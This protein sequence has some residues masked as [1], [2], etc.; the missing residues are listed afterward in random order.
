MKRLLA[1]GLAIPILGATLVYR[2]SMDKVIK[3]SIILSPDFSQ[4]AFVVKENN[5]LFSVVLNGREVGKYEGILRGSLFFL[6]KNLFFVA[7]QDNRWRAYWGDRKT[8]PYEVVYPD[9]LTFKGENF[10]LVG[11]RGNRFFVNISGTEFGPF[12][13]VLRNSI[14]LGRGYAFA[15]KRGD[16]WEFIFHGK[17][18]GTYP[19]ILVDTILISP[20]WKHWTFIVEGKPQ[21]LYLDGKPVAKY[22][23]FLSEHVKVE[24]GGKFFRTTYGPRMKFQGKH[25]V[26]YGVKGNKIYFEK[27]PL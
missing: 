1:L 13:G 11:R 23:Y 14:R 26:F 2:G 8:D 25:L 12:E 19:L 21:V 27:I 7:L 9:S 22:D 4:L 24:R 18:Q 17:S 6:G 20:D 10:A 3:N 5:K 16:R 15:V